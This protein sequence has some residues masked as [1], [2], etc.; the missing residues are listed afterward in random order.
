VSYLL[1]YLGAGNVLILHSRI[2]AKTM[3]AALLRA[4]EEKERNPSIGSLFVLHGYEV[5]DEKQGSG[6]TDDYK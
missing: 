2:E 1:C 4:D 3:G 6:V 5:E